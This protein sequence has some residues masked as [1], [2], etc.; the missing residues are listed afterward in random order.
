MQAVGQTYSTCEAAE[1]SL[2]IR[3]TEAVEG[4]GLTKGKA[5]RQN[6]SRTQGR[7]NDVPNALDRIRQAAIRNKDERFTA[8][9]HHIT[10]ERLS[11]AFYGIKRKAAAGV[12]GV[13]WDWYEEN[14]EGNLPDLCARI[15]R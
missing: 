8:L 3:T 1:Q 10:L 7:T 6:T 2:E 9:L 13:T 15:Q 5:A 11:A 4:R 14:L 12:D